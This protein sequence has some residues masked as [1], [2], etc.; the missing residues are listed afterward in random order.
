MKLQIVKNGSIQGWFIS[1]CMTAWLL[2]V[3]TLAVLFSSIADNIAKIQLMIGGVYA[4]QFTAWL[5]YRTLKKPDE[6]GTP[7]A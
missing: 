3:M 7:P 5:G 1:A 4:I 2:A 6:V